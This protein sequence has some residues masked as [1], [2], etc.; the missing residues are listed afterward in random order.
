VGSAPGKIPHVM[1]SMRQAGRQET[2]QSL[3]L[4]VGGFTLIELLAVMTI[5]L[6]LAG[7]ILSIAGNANYKAATSR[8]QGEIQAISTAL[9]SYKADNGAYPSSSPSAGTN[10]LDPTAMPPADP[11]GNTTYQAA[12]ETLFQALAGVVVTSGTATLTGKSYYTYNVSQIS[13]TSGSMTAPPTS[14]TSLQTTYFVDP[15][16]F[17]YGYSTYYASEIQSAAAAGT[18]APN[19]GNGY[20]PTF[21]LW[22]TAGYSASAG[23]TYPTNV[24]PSNSLWVKNW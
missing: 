17:A 10:I 14:S 22:S 21:D 18:A 3:S 24:T 9:E 4:A 2:A 13:S 15:F 5:I 8:A 20:N 1:V 6:I 16:G 7:L 19:P 11:A 23:K 12:G